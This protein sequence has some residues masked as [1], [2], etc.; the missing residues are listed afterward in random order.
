MPL[1]LKAPFIIFFHLGREENLKK[2]KEENDFVLPF[3]HP[4]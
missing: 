1:D 3:P 2:E 4:F